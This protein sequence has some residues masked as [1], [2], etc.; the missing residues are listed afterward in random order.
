M[1]ETSDDGGRRPYPRRCF[2]DAGKQRLVA[3]ADHNNG[4]GLLHVHVA[5]T[6]LAY[7]LLVAPSDQF[8][9]KQP[10]PKLVV[11]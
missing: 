1:P 10:A 6:V 11:Q 2:G 4:P 5:H 3:G 7:Q 8:L 9:L